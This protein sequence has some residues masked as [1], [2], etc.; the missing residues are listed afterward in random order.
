MA[1][2][3]ATAATSTEAAA[4]ASPLFLR[5]RL[6]HRQ[7]PAVKLRTVQRF[8]RFLRFLRRAHGDESETTRPA[9]RAIGQQVGLDHGAVRRK[10]VLQIVFGCVERKV[11]HEYFSVHMMFNVLRLTLF[12]PYC[13]R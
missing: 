1:R 3:F 6:I 4:A 2:V 7:A 13:S 9:G 11:P 5:T 12:S 8:N 10:S